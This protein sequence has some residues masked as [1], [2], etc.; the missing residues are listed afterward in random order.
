MA[1][2]QMK[3]KIEFEILAFSS[4][5]PWERWLAKNHAKSNGVWLQF[6]KKNSGIATIA[7]S[8][9]LDAALCHGWIDGQVRKHDAKSWL[10][11]FTPRRPKSLWSKRN[12]EHIERLAAS[13]RMR[14][15]GLKLVADA[16]ADGRWDRAYD[17]P[18]QMAVPADL[19]KLLD[20]AKKAKRFFDSLNKT[21]RYAIAWR[22]QTAVKP[23]TRKRR[24]KVILEMLRQG[25]KF[26]E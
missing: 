15:A 3:D 18:S 2:R 10:H 25:R 7:Y 4:G 9:A 24:L 12:C 14:A 26:H 13:G 5:K 23:V 1:A 21:N 22:L 16:K 8:E 11:K 6:F 17:S 20:R 19:L